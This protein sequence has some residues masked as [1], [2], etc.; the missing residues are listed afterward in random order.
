MCTC[1]STVHVE[2]R[3][4]DHA[5]G[6]MWEEKPPMPVVGSKE[7]LKHLIARKTETKEAV[8]MSP[9]SQKPNCEP[10]SC[11][12]GCC[13]GDKTP[14]MGFCRE[15]RAECIPFVSRKPMANVPIS[16]GGVAIPPHFL[17]ALQCSLRCDS[18]F[19]SCPRASWG[20]ILWSNIS[21]TCKHLCLLDT[22]LEERQKTWLLCWCEPQQDQHS[23]T[24][25]FLLK[26]TQ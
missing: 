9:V 21:V 24:F 19:S 10:G 18:P 14:A 15:Q 7:S 23:L 22:C 26:K 2:I 1:L 17:P 6:R 3:P 16:L 13:P 4:L 11:W 8:V 20:L 5:M 12:A 25:S